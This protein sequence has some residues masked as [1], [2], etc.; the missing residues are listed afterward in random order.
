MLGQESS[1]RPNPA[2][3]DVDLTISVPSITEEECSIFLIQSK[4]KL[5]KGQKFENPAAEQRSSPQGCTVRAK[6][7]PDRAREGLFSVPRDY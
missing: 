3:G 6:A 1:T 5:K 2:G 7:S 4:Y